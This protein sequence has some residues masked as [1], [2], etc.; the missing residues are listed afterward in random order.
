MYEGRRTDAAVKVQRIILRESAW[1]FHR[2]GLLAGV[3]A[4][5]IVLAANQSAVARQFGVSA[6]SVAATTIAATSAI[7]SAQQAATATQQ[8]MQSLAR[9][10]LAIQ[11]MQAVQSAA[12]NAALSGP[13][14]LGANPNQPGLLLPNV[15]DGLSAGGLVPDSG[16]SAHGIANPVTSWTNAKTPSQTSVNGQTTVTIQQTAQKAILNWINFNVGKNTTVYFNQSAGTASDGSNGWVA[17]NRIADPSGVPSQILGAIKAEGSVY[18]L[19]RNGII[20]GGS[21]Q[22]NVNTFLATS[23]NLFSNDPTASNNRFLTGGIGDLNATNVTPSA[24]DPL[25]HSILLTSSGPGAGDVIIE[26]GAAITVGT[27]GLAL[28]A[29][30]N[31]TNGGVIM[32]PSGQVALIAGIGVSYDYNLSSLNPNGSST[33]PQGTNDNKTT[34][35]RFANYGALTDASGNDITPVGTLINNGLIYTPRGNITLLGGAIQQNGAA[36]ATTSVA[37]PGSIVISSVYEVGVNSGSKS[38]ADEYDINF[39]TG[40]ISFGPQAVTSI[41]PDGNGVTLSSDATSLA[42][43][44][45]LPGAASLT[46]MLPTQGPGLIA[47]VGQAIDFQGGT[48]V[49]APGQTVSASTL[50]VPDQRPSVPPVP[51]SGRILLESGAI[52][53]VS[54]IPDSV[55]PAASNLL[56]VKLAGNELADSPLQQ[57]SFLY[58]TTVTVDMGKSGINPVT[59]EPWVGTPLAN[60]ASYANLVQRSIGQLLVNGGSIYLGANEMI[61][62]PGSVINLTGGY[63]DY[64]GGTIRTTVLIGADGRRYSVGSANPSLTY[65][66]IAGQFTVDHAHWGVKEIYSDPLTNQGSYQVEYVQGGN[67]G[68]LTVSVGPGNGILRTPVIANSGATILDS[69]LLAGTVAGTRQVAGGALPSDGTFN[70]TGILPIE[71]GDPGVMSAPSSAAASLPANFTPDTP[72]LATPGSPY[73]AANVFSSQTLNDANFKN[74]SFTNSS[75]QAG[76]AS[77]STDASITVDGGA[78]LAVQPG[79]SITLAGG[80]VT[81]NGSLTARAGAIS[82]TTSPATTTYGTFFNNNVAG[83]IVIGSSAVLDVSG[84]FVNDALLPPDQQGWSVLVDAGSISLVTRPGII[85]TNGAGGV[86]IGDLTGNITLAAGSLLNLEGGGHVLAKGQLQTGS[87]GV[88]L[89]SGGNLTLAT[90]Q[91]IGT[92]PT[93]DGTP[94]NRGR[95]V[96]NGVIDALGFNGG[97]SLT[98]GAVALQIG[99]AAATTPSYA[100]YFDPNQWGS[101]GFGSFNLSSVLQSEV[102]AGAIVRLEHQNLLPNPT[103]VSASGGADP[104]AYS[105]AGL[106]TGTTRSPTN[107]SVTAG[108]EEQSNPL[109]A[110]ASGSD[111]AEVGLGAQI[112]ADPG[113]SV[114]INSIVMTSILGTVSAPGGT[115]SLAVSYNGT[116]GYGSAPLGPLYLGP[117]SVLDVSGTAVVNSLATPL[118]TRGGPVTPYTGQILAGGTINLTD[119]WSPILVAPGAILN[120]SGAAG[121]FDVARLAPDGTLGGSHLVLD[122]TPVWSDAGLINIHGAAGLLFEGTLIGHPGA[123]QAAGGSLVITGDPVAG[124]VLSA[125]LVLVED[126]AAAVTDAAVWAASVRGFSRPSFNFATYVPGVGNPVIDGNIGAGSI[127]FGADSLD[128]SGFSSLVLNNTGGAVGFT[129]QVALTLG[130][131]FIV[132]AGAVIAANQGNYGGGFNGPNN[133]GGGTQHPT[134][135]GASLSVSAPYIAVNGLSVPTGNSVRPTADGTLTLSADQLDLSGS[136]YLQYIGQANFISSGDIRLLPG[137]SAPSKGTQLLGYLQTTGN[138]AFEAADIYPA[139]DTAFVIQ[140]A[141]D[142]THPGTTPSPTTVSFSYPNGGGPSSTTPL[143]AGGTLL[144]S[145]TDIIQNGQIQAPFGSIILGVTGTSSTL[146]AA[147]GN[148]LGGFNNRYYAPATSTLTVTLGSGSITSVSANG[149]VIPYG[150]TVDQTTW[151]YN[152]QLNNP[153]WA[154]QQ[155]SLTNPLTEAPQ[156]TITLTGAS[157]AFNSGAVVNLKGGGDLQAQEWIPGTGG[158]RDV[159]SQY[160]TSYASSTSGTQVPLYPDARQVFAIV[161]GYAGKVAPYD[162]TLSQSGLTAGAAVYL[163]GGPGLPAGYYTLLPAKYATLPGAFRVVVN[164]GVVNPLSNQTQLLADGTMEVSGYL[165]NAITGTRPSATAQFLVQSAATWGQ[166]S[167]YAVTSANSFFPT[168]ASL[169]GLAAPNVPVDAGRLVLAATTGLTFG[170]SLFGDPAPGGFGAQVDISSQFIQIVGSGETLQPGYLGVSA[171]GLD[172]LGAASLLIGGTRSSTTTG[173]AITPTANGVIVSTDA[174]TPLSA[175]EIILVAAPQFQSST[176]Q[177]DKDGDTAT[178]LVPVANSGQV[179]VRSGSV[180]QATGSVGANPQTRLIMGST[181]ANLPTLPSSLLVSDI[182]ASGATLLANYYK[183][184]DAALGTLVR[185]SNGSPVTVQLPSPAQISPASITVTDNVN[186]ANPA[187]TLTLPALS[188]V[189]SGTGAVIEA[190]AQIRGGNSLTFASTGDTRVAAGASLSTRNFSAISSSITFVGSGAAPTS[191]MAIDA[192]LLAAL[193]QSETVNLQSYG[194]IAFHGDVNFAMANTDGQALLTLGAGSVASDGGHVTI[195]APKLVL[196]NELNAALPST[197]AAGSGSLAI[198]VGQLVFGVGARTLTGFGS[199]SL[200]ASQAVIGQG[201]GSFDFGSLPV[202]LQTPIV[203]ADTASSQ[204]LTTTGALSVVSIAGNALTSTAL[205]GAIALQGGSVNVSAPIQAWAGNISLQANAGD[206][207]VTRTGA[208]IAHGIAKPFFDLIE[209]ASAGSITLAANQGTVNIETGAVIDFAGAASGGNG[210]SLTIRTRNGTAPVALNGTLLGATAA[211]YTGGSFNLD[212]GGAAVLDD[213]AQVLTSAGVTGGISVHTGLGDLSLSKNLTASKISLVADGGGVIVT[214]NITANGTSNTVGEIDLYGATGVDVEGTLVATGS[215]ASQKPGGLIN[216]GTTG[217]GSTTLLDPT[218]RYENIDP[219]NS[220][221]ITIGSNALI[222]ASGGIIT[223]RAPILDADNANGMNVNI[224]I[225]SSFNQRKGIFGGAVVLDAY[226]VWSTADQSANPNQHFDGIVDPAGWYNINSNGVPVLVAGSF[227]DFSGNTVAIW[228]GTTLSGTSG[229]PRDLSYYLSNDYFAPSAG[230]NAAHAVFYGGYNPNTGTFD[231]AHPDAGSL[232]AFVQKVEFHLGSS[233]TGID[234][235]QARPEIDLIN[236]S[237]TDGG[238]NG[239]TI[240]VLTNWNLGAGVQN[241]DGSRTLAYRYQNAIAP[242]IALRA[243]G[244]VRIAASISDG[245]FQTANVV[246]PGSSSG[247][248]PATLD[249]ALAA[250]NSIAGTAGD[251]SSVTQIGLFDGTSQLLGTQDPNVVLAAPQAG[252]STQYYQDYQDYLAQLYNQWASTFVANNGFFLPI[253]APTVAPPAPVPPGASDPNFAGDYAAYLVAY[254]SW[255]TNNFTTANLQTSGTP[256]AVA[257]PANPAQYEAYV[258]ADRAYL[259]YAFQSLFDGTS[260]Y[261]YAPKAPDLITG[262]PTGPSIPV[263]ANAPSNMATAADPLPVQ[264]AGLIA[265][266]SASYRI[267]A[268]AALGSANPLALANAS[269]FAAGSTSGLA[270]EGNVVLDGHLLYVN[271]NT[272]AIVGPTT[273]RTGTGSIDIAAA[274]DFALLDPLAPGVVY[275]AGTPVQLAIGGDATSVVLGLGSFKSS[276]FASAAGISTILTSETNPADAGNITLTVLGNIV[277]VENVR[278]TLANTT[279]APSGLTSSPGAFIGQFWLSWLLTN[280]ANPSVPWYVNFGSFDQGIMS[281]GGNVTVSAGGDIHDLAVSLPTTAWLDGANALHL[282]GGGNLSVTAGGSIYSGDFFVGRGPGVIK[283]GGAIG[284]DFTYGGGQQAV[285]V[286]TLLAVQYG[287]I[288]VEARQSVDIGGVYDPTYLW[289]THSSTNPLNMFYGLSQPPVASYTSGFAAPTVLVPYVTSM[290][291]DSG[292]SVQATGGS[293]RFNSQLEQ[294]GLFSLGVQVG[295]NANNTVSPVAAVTSLLLPA[296]LSLVALD[297]GITIDHGGGLYP[298]ATGTLTI[299]ADQSINLQIPALVGTDISGTTISALPSFTSVGNVFGNVLGKLDYPVGTGI[300]PTASNPALVDVALLPPAQTHDPSLI[301]DT[302]SAPVQIVALNGSIVDGTQSTINVSNNSNGSFA[303]PGGTFGQISLIPNA[304]AQIQAGLDVLDLPLFGENFTAADVTSLIAGRDIRS[305]IFGSNQYAAI[306]LAGPGAL[307]VEAGRDINFPS[308]R[309]A[310]AN[311][312][313]ETGIRTIGN[314]IDTTANPFNVF[315]SSTVKPT[316]LNDF[317]NPYLPAGGA[318]ANVLFGVGPGIDQAAFI[319]QY[320]N[321]ANAGAVTPSSTAALIAFVDQYEIASGNA[322][323]APQTADQAWTIFQTLPAAQQQLLVQ[324]VFAGILNATG[325]DYNNPGSPFNLQ[326]SRGYQAINTLFPASLGYTANGLGST[327]GANQLIH[328]G[329]LDMRGAT[330]QTQQGGNIAIFGPG[331]RILVG[332]SIASPAVNPASEGILTL[333]QGNIDIFVDQDALVAQS[334]V[335]TEQGGDIVMWSSNGNL[336]AG[337][338]AKTS[339]SAPPPKYACDIDWICAADIKGAVSGAGIATL[340]SLPGVPV[341]NANLVAP[342]GTVDAGA[343]G[344]RTSGNLNIAALIVANAF[345]IQS[346]GTV[347]GIPT[348]AAPNING[349]LTASNTTAA[350]QQATSPA[351]ANNNGQPSIIIVEVLGYGGGAD[352]PQDPPNERQRRSNDDRHSDNLAPAYNPKGPVRI[353]GLGVLTDEEKRSLSEGEK[354]EL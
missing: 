30:P 112:L 111:Y 197:V 300:L 178:V 247:G 156:G 115:I 313:V 350:T 172:N 77:A 40:S 294:G 48:L 240:S 43:F 261:I 64:L 243:A 155:S 276:S 302:P 74:V 278:D 319:N 315:Q 137:Q 246:L 57:S 67:A 47:I 136:I 152:P 211:G 264:F 92:P 249:G 164:S 65:I 51:G 339:V 193:E 215:P 272:T 286:Q 124:G 160:N 169:N 105:T 345:N 238:V 204:L 32:A 135:Y 4:I 310:A 292:V 167:Q 343:A 309:S 104:A 2:R 158:S 289:Y 131:S 165:A 186:P 323:N 39:Y 180:I 121:A 195:S 17:L 66:G 212:I 196:D 116:G 94:P 134:T 279:L 46:T 207:V 354:H 29:A 203:I 226:A 182:K 163:A 256:S 177:L 242:V 13:N 103:I 101:L 299:V 123:A 83:D 316:F 336:D 78:T 44:Q 10:T 153:S 210:G 106:L 337:K 161:P 128:G 93:A 79:G 62:A 326:Y 214:G 145:A 218:Y 184:L 265:G 27:Q 209:Y 346:Q 235:F 36:I 140:A 332:S 192:G 293:V 71:I 216:I 35:L 234:H 84:W 122:R 268:G 150:N 225:P 42:P 126:A 352:S 97:G 154:A 34:N 149:M 99:G 108:L 142:S 344:I 288:A 86:P 213:L 239:G 331:G 168:Y 270:G 148:A 285:P 237:P 96:L 50:V 113:A 95:L 8:S 205:G 138:L 236:P 174:G 254:S 59:G 199:L 25:A 282:T 271:P 52:L 88:P 147:I 297:G 284:S 89:G 61:G 23:L 250:Y 338:G 16:L 267:V 201:T 307:M 321:P 258:T 277:G 228:D 87:N 37:Q 198:D 252:G 291:P 118:S 221:T 244:N 12:R 33:G 20:F 219:S 144:V 98:L 56:T 90:Y 224:S 7:V 290:G 188:G 208:L 70:F 281:V 327:N 287:T 347:T 75:N 125:S 189:A 317:G 342:R 19:N 82:I 133:I 117:Q 230:Y 324:Q 179:V 14:N 41:L 171:A 130:N 18:L 334:R 341:G 72:L 109:G 15:P 348:V 320:I 325:N 1:R 206:V 107:L 274:G 102:P 60:L 26:P 31:V 314:S 335:M 119:D 146:N 322:A 298:S 328:T 275:T 222:N 311:V 255:L 9:A 233:L 296:S 76:P 55:L 232:P 318:S 11:A 3:S 257:A 139:T 80:N 141:L 100:F 85:T 6:Q 301:Q 351:Q 259:D 120:V 170:G 58:G 24:S 329:D 248:G 217:T 127:L 308:Q 263:N 266:Q 53:D 73:A 54:G 68:T 273:V 181:L 340:Q 63:I 200:V 241:S 81:I 5:V 303:F 312:I 353:L 38:P 305:N 28:I 151:I 187:F 69:T 245:F 333:E 22:V 202:T 166:Y 110:S 173:T 349:A 114:S 251:F 45:N 143:S 280:P 91:G 306:E 157:V 183:A 229:T 129:G 304:P 162:A 231:P 295:A 175:P 283:A 227:T 190:G 220:G 159:L 132:N 191:G 176:I 330:I 269:N 21:S 260:V 185:V 262:G 49:Y 223:F 194:A 253:T